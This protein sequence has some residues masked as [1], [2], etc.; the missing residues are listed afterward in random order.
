MFFHRGQHVFRRRD[1]LDLVP[2]HLH[3]PGFRRLVQ[4]IHNL[5]VDIGALFEG[6]VEFDFADL[7]PEGGLSQLRDRKAI[8]AD[9][10]GGSLRI[11]HLGIE[12]AVDADLYVVARDA[13]LFGNIDGGFFQR[14]FV[15]HT[16]EERPQDVEPRAECP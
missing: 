16:V 4:L 2:Q 14:V 11:Q 8:V 3:A 13:D 1:V 6:A 10:V 15:L 7:A 12:N 5:A 9:A